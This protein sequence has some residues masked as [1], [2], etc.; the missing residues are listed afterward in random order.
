MSHELRTPLNAII[1]F[2]EIIMSGVFGTDSV[3]KNQ[4]YAKDI[5]DSGQHLLDLI[6]DILD[7]SKIELG[8]E[9]PDDVD[10]EV[11]Q[12]IASVLVLMKERAHK[13]N[14]MITTDIQQDMPLFSVDER[15]LKQILINLLSNSIKFTHPG[16]H[17]TL[18]VSC[19][20]GDG[21]VFAV[22]DT[23]IGIAP[24]NIAKA[25]QPFGQID[26]DLNRAYAGTGLGLPLAKELAEM[27]GGTLELQ[28]QLGAGT[29]VT[30]CFPASR[31][32][33]EA[34][35]ETGPGVGTDARPEARS[36][37]RS[38]ALPTIPQLP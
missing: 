2:S 24:E 12:I 34:R 36:D 4:E 19:G 29:T 20:V 30:V 35:R 9:E 14:I 37:A 10:V 38:A 22:T 15:K 3:E 11:P 25:L 17:V 16:G 26:S 5:F 7:I 1:G 18:S 13:A 6:N 21:F 33:P 23:G 27:H 32:V 28:S 31:I 8:S